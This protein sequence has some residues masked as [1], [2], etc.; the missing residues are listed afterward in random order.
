MV[1]IIASTP[2]QSYIVR[3]LILYLGLRSDPVV[4]NPGIELLLIEV[5][6]FACWFVVRNAVSTRQLIEVALAD[7]KIL[8]CLLHGERL[9]LGVM[10]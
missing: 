6:E 9:V 4:Q 5:D 2:S 3:P 10:E 8:R 7:M 1:L